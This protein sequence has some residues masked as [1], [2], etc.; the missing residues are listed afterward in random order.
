MVKMVNNRQSADDAMKKKTEKRAVNWTVKLHREK[1]RNLQFVL[2]EFLGY[3]FCFALQ[4]EC[5]RG[6]R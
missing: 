2:G 6:M 3:N 1:L 5:E 4:L